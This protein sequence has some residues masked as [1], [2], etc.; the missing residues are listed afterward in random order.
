LLP[1]LG[2]ENGCSFC[3][4]SH[5]F[6]KRYVPLLPT[7]KD[8]FAACR[9]AEDHDRTTGFSV[10]DENFLKQPRRARELLAEM[11]AEGKPYVFDL[12]SSAE[13]I[14]ALGTDFLVR[15]GVHLVWIG[16]ETRSN[17]H[18]KVQGIDVKA[19][20]QELQDKGIVVQA[21]SILFQD[22]HDPQTIEEDID[23]VIDLDA[24][25][26][27]FMNYTPYPST[28]LY[29]QLEREGRLE[30]VHY[31]HLHGQGRLAF[32]HP[33]F[34][35]AQDH[36]EILRQ[37]FRRKYEADGPSVLNMAITAIRGYERACR[38]HRQRQRLG[39][40]WNPE[41][42]R[43]E[44]SDSPQPDRFMELRLRKMEKIAFNIRP[45][46]EASAV[47]AP[48]AAAR[49]KA[50]AT[51]ELYNRVLGKPSLKDRARSLTLVA[52]G[53]LEAAR[54][55]WHQA[56]G[57]ESIPRQPPSKRVTYPLDLDLKA[58][59]PARQ[60]GHLVTGWCPESFDLP[61]LDAGLDIMAVPATASQSGYDRLLRWLWA[62]AGRGLPVV[63][64]LPPGGS[65]RAEAAAAAVR[66]RGHLPAHRRYLHALHA[67]QPQRNLVGLVHVRRCLGPRR[68]RR[69][70]QA[71]RHREAHQG[72][73]GDLPRDGLAGAH[74]H[75]AGRRR[76]FDGW[77]HLAVG[78]WRGLHRG[79][80]LL[81]LR[82][83]SLW[84]R[85]LAWLRG[86]RLGVPRCCGAQPRGLRELSAKL[87]SQ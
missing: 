79:G 30:D 54:L 26:T 69:G 31:R 6:E 77:P 65:R 55:S 44:A 41:T 46:L 84:S 73:D 35:D 34:P 81:R 50:R 72:V 71:L 37:A 13:T 59:E 83:H 70:H 20:I 32:A 48:N 16:V 45:I 75:Q 9:K 42:L 49:T 8:V 28:G 40:C 67:A 36:V 29:Q 76:H 21:S 17:T 68:H 2:C 80:H 78:R 53:A 60:T 61:E 10:M 1:G 82:P 74:R 38:E 24:N 15:L 19:M 11:E 33:H 58:R 85:H 5:K 56:R 7:G 52:T 57:H 64:P 4:T 86:L 63:V 12:F 22:H 47:Y 66:S 14:Q 27:Q 87:R 39:Q 3:V 23:W 43:Y 25:L 62:V 18:S 51:I